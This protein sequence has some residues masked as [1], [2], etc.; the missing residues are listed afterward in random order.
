MPNRTTVHV[1]SATAKAHKVRDLVQ[2]AINTLE[3]MTNT[4]ISED[5][6]LT[7]VDTD[8][9]LA[10]MEIQDIQNVVQKVI[11]ERQAQAQVRDAAVARHADLVEEAQALAAKFSITDRDRRN[12]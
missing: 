12:V 9:F 8:L 6:A 5:C 4:T 1:E 7:C 2:R 3:K 10:A 11:A